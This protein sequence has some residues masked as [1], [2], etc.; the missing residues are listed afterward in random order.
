MSLSTVGKSQL[1]VKQ[2]DKIAIMQS[3]LRTWLVVMLL[4]SFANASPAVQLFNQAANFIQTQYF[5]SSAVSI[6]AL[7]EKYRVEVAIT[8]LRTAQPLQC[9]YARVEPV[10]VRLFADL[11]DGHAY[12]LS[13]EAV[14]QEN[15][16]RAG[17][18]ITPRPVLGLRF[19]NF[20]DTPN[21]ECEF[22][23]QK[24][25][26]S[27]VLREQLIIRVSFDSPAETA[28]VRYGD[29]LIGYN[30]ILFSSFSSETD[31]LQ[32]RAELTPKV[33][34]G[35]V[36]TLNLLR[37]TNRQR[38]DISLKGAVINASQ[39]PRLEIRRDGIA[40]LTVR[41]YQISGVGKIIHDLIRQAEERGAKAIIFEERQNGGGSVFEMMQAVGAFVPNPEPFRFIPHYN[42]DRD[43][44]E[45]GYSDGRATIRQ[46]SGRIQAGSIINNPVKTK[47]PL[48][49]LVDENCASG[50]EYFATYMQ[51]NKRGTVIGSATAG[52]GN[53]N[54][55]RFA[56][57]NGGSAGIPTL[58]AF[59]TDG[60]SLPASVTAD[61]AQPIFQWNLFQTGRDEPLETAL[62]ILNK[63]A[64]S[65]LE[66]SQMVSVPSFLQP[67]TWQT[68]NLE[69]T[70]E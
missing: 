67:L 42:P 5:G 69:P 8:C 26:K 70:E 18:N 63:P 58:R 33:Q 15:A 38:V 7:L 9:D 47:L 64:A 13:A 40:V 36:I 68:H 65:Q 23:E 16:N 4:G 22:D 39:A 6:P 57:A 30:N 48:A 54:T 2:L 12:Y 51:R 20:C 61:I 60:T 41:D 52:V 29:R 17:Q 35:E 46:G 25:L 1:N 31:F 3:F 14:R 45:F 34:A 50:C 53:S 24:N 21:G 10:L 27:T 11:E 43:T 66:P 59:W 37:G 49:V 19:A 55:A 62:Q 28:G 56:L 32:F 44:L